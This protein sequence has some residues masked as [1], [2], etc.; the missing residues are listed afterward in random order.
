MLKAKQY[1]NLN[2]LNNMANSENNIEATANSKKDSD[3][4]S[5][6][7]NIIDKVQQV[8]AT[9][10][11]WLNSKFIKNLTFPQKL[12]TF[13]HTKSVGAVPSLLYD[14]YQTKKNGGDYRN[15]LIKAILTFGTTELISMGLG[16]ALAGTGIGAAL[17]AT[18][19]GAV[20][21]SAIITALAIAGAEKITD[22]LINTDGILDNWAYDPFFNKDNMKDDLYLHMSLEQMQKRYAAG[23]PSASNILEKPKRSIYDFLQ[24]PWRYFPMS[25]Y[26]GRILAIG[27]PRVPYDNF[28]ALLHEGESV[29]TKRETNNLHNGLGGVNI[30]KLS[31]TIVVREEADIDRIAT[32]LASRIRQAALN[33]A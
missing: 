4:D 28:P 14:L 25:N 32:A 31:D 18:G 23:A 27:L 2:S 21:L 15:D 12:F 10:D 8:A 29:L 7:E 11:N 33:M 13:F 16:A 24:H 6:V 3:Q 1:V 5:L 20:V 30:A 17:A 19:I 9:F 22:Y 26:P